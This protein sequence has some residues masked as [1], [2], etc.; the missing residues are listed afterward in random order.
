MSGPVA[1]YASVSDVSAETLPAAA[2]TNEVVATTDAEPYYY[3]SYQRLYPS[4]Q[5][6]PGAIT[7]VTTSLHLELTDAFLLG[8][9]D[10]LSWRISGTDALTGTSAIDREDK[11]VELALP[12]NFYDVASSIWPDTVHVVISSRSRSTDRVPSVPERFTSN[13][14][15]GWTSAMDYGLVLQPARPASKPTLTIPLSK[16]DVSDTL[17]R[18]FWARTPE[19]TVID[20]DT[21]LRFQSSDP[22]WAPN[23]VTAPVAYIERPWLDWS[24]GA[25]V[26]TS[27]RPS[28]SAD[29]SSIAFP[30]SDVAG[31]NTPAIDGASMIQF[32]AGA[33]DLDWNGTY[34]TTVVP[35][36]TNTSI[37]NTRSTRL[38]GDDRYN[39]SIAD[40]ALAFPNRARK[41]YLASGEVFADALSAGPAAVHNGAPLVLVRSS[42]YASSN[43]LAWLRPEEIVVLGGQASTPDD[44]IEGILRESKLDPDSYALRRDA[45]ADRYGASLAISASEFPEGAATAFL[46]SGAG[47]ADALTAIP[48]ASREEAPVILIRGDQPRL[49]DATLAELER[50]GVS[51]IV[52]TGGPASVSASIEKQLSQLYPD[53]VVRFG[54]ATRFEV[55]ESLNAAYFPTAKTAYVAT[56]ANFPDALTGGVLAGVTGAPL[57][58]ARTECLPAS[59]WQRLAAWAPSQVTL[60]GGV[61]SLASSMESLPRCN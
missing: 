47:F 51:H 15:S 60:L 29:N 9:S 6:P 56:G 59:T 23:G 55:A 5:N 35:I 16:V 61:N 38:A 17:T 13:K 10:S 26:Q 12:S 50:L 4:N 3:H 42:H 18:F 14:P 24:A 31:L 27:K 49:D 7:P 33:G 34:A 44:V 1:A 37:A 43:Y 20:R 40:A 22:I 41:V 36:G 19:G 21:T 30:F 54:G 2:S 8:A 32:T 48:A 45:G 57:V 46:A 52:I 53:S 25:R 58:L 39:G 28:V 11:S